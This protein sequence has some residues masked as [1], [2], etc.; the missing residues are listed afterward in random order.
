MLFFQFPALCLRAV[1][2]LERQMEADTFTVDHVQPQWSSKIIY[3]SQTSLTLLH[4]S[5][6]LQG[7]KNPWHTGRALKEQRVHQILFSVRRGYIFICRQ[8]K[9]FPISVGVRLANRLIL[10]ESIFHRKLRLKPFS[11]PNSRQGPCHGKLPLCSVLR[12]V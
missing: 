2:Q 8:N 3:L 12:G 4:L 9:T 11:S 10:L 1:Q 6:L 7:R 5:R